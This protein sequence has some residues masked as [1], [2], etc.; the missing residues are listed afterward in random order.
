MNGKIFGTALFALIMLVSTVFAGYAPV[1][2]GVSGPS[3]LDAGQAGNWSV[4]AYAPENGTLSYS[5]AWGDEQLASVQSG[6]QSSQTATFTHVYYN[7]GNYTPTFTITDNESLT[8]QTS[9]S[10]EVRP[11][12]PPD[13]TTPPEVSSTYSAN[14]STFSVT[15][16]ATDSSGI[17]LMQI[18][19]STPANSTIAVTDSVVK[20][21][22]SSPCTYSAELAAG[23][24]YYFVSAKDA[25][26]NH[27]E[28]VTGR[29]YFAI[30]SPPGNRAPVITGVSGPTSLNANQT[31]TWA[32]SAYDPESGPLS[33]S[34]VWGDEYPSVAS[35]GSAQQV[36]QTAT[37]THIY[38]DSGTYAPRFTVTD[39]HNLTAQASITVRVGS[40][41]GDQGK[42]GLSVSVE[43]PSV[44]VGDS[45]LVTDSITYTGIS[46]SAAPQKFMVVTSYTEKNPR[47]V[48]ARTAAKASVAKL[49]G[50]YYAASAASTAAVKKSFKSA[51]ASD[52][53][54]DEADEAE[55]HSGSGKPKPSATSATAVSN[56]AATKPI[57]SA[58][59]ERTDYITL[60]PGESTTLSAYFVAR[61]AGTNTVTVRVYKV[62][63][64][65][66]PTA[67][68]YS[69]RA[70][71]D[72]YV[73][74][75]QESATVAVSGDGT[76]PQ[77]P[78]QPGQKAT[79]SLYQGWNMVSVPLNGKVDMGIVAEACGSPS[80]AW[81]LTSGGYVK[82][83]TL[84]P[85]YGY[86]I[87]AGRDCEFG[88]EADAGSSFSL[89]KLFPGWNLVGAPD[90]EVA[91][92]DYAGT[93]S[94]TSGPWYY[95]HVT[96]SATASP[97]YVYSSKLVPG[98]AYWIK[99]P[100]SCAL[101]GAAAEDVP[102]QPPE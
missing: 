64:S 47:A 52:D 25:S 74:V 9:I 43:P 75:A 67:A 97:S 71:R 59:Q 90:H 94:I 62:S 66:P 16:N 41:G 36:S 19:L 35:G 95:S 20:E 6:V 88:V 10:V 46:A 68:S 11:V 77:P 13:D 1:V 60:A 54:E 91:I 89:A 56:I 53:S 57:A 49:D 84:V 61:S 5:V 101:G 81:R 17:S 92:A 102:P 34:V 14:G 100:D 12:T 73:L 50:K 51:A 33:Y 80:Y 15:A 27:N 3:Y 32:V 2:S 83:K 85:G 8:A 79:V 31:G 45:F 22:D 28:R 24:Y 87:K 93:C 78:S 4:T 76:P 40:S 48:A 26:A 29:T 98:Q 38:Y 86:W 18:H 58:G 39:D 37:F 55:A 99:V 63:Q 70:C 7:A 65:C 72:G 96:S 23:S 82:D 44:G 30:V 69:D 21:C 42:V